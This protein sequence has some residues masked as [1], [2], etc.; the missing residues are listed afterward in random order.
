MFTGERGYDKIKE[1]RGVLV[2]FGIVLISLS[3]G[4][5]DYSII[6]KKNIFT[7]PI[8]QKPIIEKRPILKPPSLTSLIELKGIIFFREGPSY[9]I[10]NIKKKGKD[11]VFEEG[12]KIGEIKILKI[13]KNE[14]VFLYNGKEEMLKIKSKSQSG[15]YVKV[16]PGIE[17]KLDKKEK[18][19]KDVLVPKFE[20][21][22][23]IDFEKTITELKRDTTL[24]KNLNVNPYIKNGKIEGFRISKLPAGSLPYKYGLRDGDVIHRINGILIDSISRGFSV[25]NQIVR[26]NTRIVTVEVLRNNQ[27]VVFT[28]KLK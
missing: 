10:I 14:V 28:F 19:K 5:I 16:A 7:S 21:P 4:S 2:F 6:F 1:M 26:S 15:K 20:E 24:I 27:P 12:E 3:E 8:P 23:I 18:K 22:V 25:Y 11:F 13:K 9:A 17:V